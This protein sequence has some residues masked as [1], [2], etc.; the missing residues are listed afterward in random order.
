MNRISREKAREMSPVITGIVLVAVLY[1]AG[2]YL[3]I[4]ASFMLLIASVG[5]AELFCRK[6]FQIEFIAALFPDLFK[7]P[8]KES[9]E[10]E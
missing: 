7:R 10:A 8:S 5:L 4:W 1:F 3:Q 2:D 6:V 9:T